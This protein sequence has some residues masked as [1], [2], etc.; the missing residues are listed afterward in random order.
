V[1]S[2]NRQTESFHK[3]TLKMPLDIRP[4]HPELQK[5]AREELNEDSELIE[6]AV[7]A[8]RDWIR[9]SPHLRARNDDQFLV[10]F[11]RATKYRM[12]SA[13]KKLDMFYTLRTHI[14]ELMLDRDPYDEKVHGIIKLGLVSLF[15]LE[16]CL[17]MTS[18]FSFEF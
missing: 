17:V 3:I 8:L 6:E 14:P 5:V 1:R 15:D 2:Q 4:L 11:L 12:E 18:V 9:K 16:S 10:T 7:E 13:K